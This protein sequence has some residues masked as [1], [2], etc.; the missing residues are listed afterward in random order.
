[1]EKTKPFSLYQG[2]VKVPVQKCKQPKFRNVAF[3]RTWDTDTIYIDGVAKKVHL[4]T[5]WG[6]YLYFQDENNRWYKLR[7]FSEPYA[8]GGGYNIDPYDYHNP[9]STHLTSKPTDNENSI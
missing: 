8:K 1:M 6:T 4:D 7:M 9:S 3:G 5:T 2:K